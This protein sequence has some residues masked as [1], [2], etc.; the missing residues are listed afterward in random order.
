MGFELVVHVGQELLV[1]GRNHVEEEVAR[2]RDNGKRWFRVC[3]MVAMLP[4]VIKW[5]R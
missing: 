4:F 2:D 1:D 3:E 5:I